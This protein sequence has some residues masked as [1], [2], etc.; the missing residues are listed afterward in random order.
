MERLLCS[1]FEITLRPTVPGRSVAPITATDRGINRASKPA[2]AGGAAV[3]ILPTRDG[4]EAL[5]ASLTDF[6]P[7]A[8]TQTFFHIF[9]E[10]PPTNFRIYFTHHFTVSGTCL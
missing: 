3:K 4:A 9:S 5:G 1:R 8:R 7:L 10:S 2:R 6:L